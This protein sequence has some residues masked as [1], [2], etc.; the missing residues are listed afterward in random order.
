MRRHWESLHSCSESSALEPGEGQMGEYCRWPATPPHG[1][2]WGP[3]V[4]VAG[5]RAGH[6]GPTHRTM[7]VVA[8]DVSCQ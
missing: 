6:P 4:P 5:R 1:A 2:V 7:S 8:F 3:W